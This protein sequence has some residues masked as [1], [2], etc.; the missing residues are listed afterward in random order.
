MRFCKKRHQV[1]LILESKFFTTM[2]YKVSLRIFPKDNSS[3][4]MAAA[5]SYHPHT[6]IWLNE[7]KPTGPGR[8]LT[9]LPKYQENR[10]LYEFLTPT[11][12]A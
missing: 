10:D 5:S 4:G 6:K 1:S 8:S 11:N 7:L 2:Y 12:T 9:Y 3:E